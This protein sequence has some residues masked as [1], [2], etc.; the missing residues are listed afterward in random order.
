MITE[1]KKSSDNI[2]IVER[3]YDE[4]QI[5]YNLFW[6]DRESLAM[7]FGFWD[8]STPSH[9]D[10]LIN[11]YRLIKQLLEPIKGEKVLDAGCG[12]GG[13]SLWLAQ[14]TEACY[15]GMTLSDVQVA[16]AKNNAQKRGLTKRVF[17]E[18]GNYFATRFKDEEFDKIFCIE[19]ACHAYPLPGDLYREL[20]RIL[21]KGGVLYISDGVLLR[22]PTTQKDKK[23]LSEWFD[24]WALP[25]GCTAEE[26]KNFLNDVG[27]SFI[28]VLDKTGAIKRDV[29]RLGV[30]GKLFYYP[31]RLLTSL[32]LLSPA[33]LANTIAA[34]AQEAAYA[35][36][37]FGYAVFT[38]HKK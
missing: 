2:E 13:A 27:F 14:N 16:Q 19:S 36:K 17:F 38:A 3:Y 5:W 15:V 34:K 9:S 1:Q 20:F 6:S 7:H 28:E 35:N 33:G 26:V 31:V 4:S 25:G 10:A 11:Q 12:I 8:A 22:H 21:K 29:K 30:L 32:G 23:I 18:K 24:A 37:L